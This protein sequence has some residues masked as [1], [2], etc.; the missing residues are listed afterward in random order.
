VVVADVLFAVTAIAPL[1]ALHIFV[2]LAQTVING[3]KH[4]AFDTEVRILACG[5][6]PNPF[7][8]LTD[9]LPSKWQ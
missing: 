6:G 9:E 4:A 8:K 2:G 7:A 1:L 5:N 3:F